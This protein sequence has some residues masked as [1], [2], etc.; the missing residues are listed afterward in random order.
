MLTEILR[1]LVECF[2]RDYDIC[3]P[4]DKMQVLAALLASP[5]FFLQLEKMADKP[6]ACHIAVSIMPTL[7]DDLI[8]SNLSCKCDAAHGHV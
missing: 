8:Y 2:Q 6:R 1:L 3:M 7:T 5:L 4:E